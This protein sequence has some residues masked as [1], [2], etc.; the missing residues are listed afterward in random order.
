[1]RC[2]TDSG[3]SLAE[4]EHEEAR[5]L[6]RREQPFLDF[7]RQGAGRDPRRELDL[8]RPRRPVASQRRGARHWRVERE[9]R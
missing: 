9:P 5:C 3:G 6:A 7:P 4:R 2:V 1:M 8:S